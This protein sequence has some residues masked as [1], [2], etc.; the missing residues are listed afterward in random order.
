MVRACRVGVDGDEKVCLCFVG[1]VRTVA[2]RYKHIGFARVDD[3]NVGTVLLDKL[4]NSQSNVQIYVF[5][6]RKSSNS[7][8]VLAAMSCIEDKRKGLLC[9]QSA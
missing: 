9:R 5:F 7:T 2:E 1:N 3:T 6:I 8:S 4:S